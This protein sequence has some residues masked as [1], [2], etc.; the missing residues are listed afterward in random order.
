MKKFTKI[1]A[2]ILT[3]L[4][5][6]GALAACVG[7][8]DSTKEKLEKKDYVVV[9]LPALGIGGVETVLL[10]TKDEESVTIF[11]YKETKDA[12]E[13]IKDKDK[14]IEKAKSSGLKADGDKIKVKRSGK[15]ILI[16]TSKAIKAAGKIL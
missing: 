1:G 10:A 13:F 9:K 12:K 5:C 3:A 8:P 6:F 15:A 2:V 4:F 7:K 14:A 11:Y 16:G